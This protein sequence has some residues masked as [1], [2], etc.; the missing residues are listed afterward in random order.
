MKIVTAIIKP[1]VSWPFAP[2]K[3]R[4]SEQGVASPESANNAMAGPITDH[5][6]RRESDPVRDS[7]PT[8]KRGSTAHAAA[9]PLIRPTPVNQMAKMLIVVESDSVPLVRRA[10]VSVGRE[11]VD[12]LC[13]Q[14]VPH[15]TKTRVWLVLAKSASTDVMCSV[16]K[17]VPSC[18]IGPVTAL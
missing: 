4:Q 7:R 3:A 14:A 17:T 10:A 2:K 11:Q 16:M 1:F 5:R 15:S 13:T 12:I 9:A 18:E 6:P 8:S